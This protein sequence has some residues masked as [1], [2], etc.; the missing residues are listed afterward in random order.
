MMPIELV[1]KCT[2]INRVF[3]LRCEIRYLYINHEYVLHIFFLADDFNSWFGFDWL[4]FILHSVWKRVLCVYLL[5]VDLAVFTIYFFLGRSDLNRFHYH[6]FLLILLYVFECLKSYLIN[7]TMNNWTY[8][9]Q[10]KVYSLWKFTWKISLTKL[11][12][13]IK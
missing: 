7:W 6:T 10:L 13:Q 1:E 3:I 5:P 4:L 11:T 2:Y 9:T 12:I 8:L